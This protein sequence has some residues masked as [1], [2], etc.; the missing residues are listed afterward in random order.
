VIAV[1][2]CN[3]RA[4][5]QVSLDIYNEVWPHD[6]VSLEDVDSYK[7]SLTEHVDLLA[8]VDGRPAG[9]AVAAIQP[10]DPGIVYAL[11]TV[12]AEHRRRGV[13]TAL[14]EAVSG[15]GRE[16]RLDR[17]EVPVLDDDPESLAFAARRGFV[18]ER[19]ETGVVLELAGIEAPA[20]E[21]PPGVEIV[22][23]AER[24]ELARGM[25]EVALEAFPDVPGFEDDMMEPFA[26][27]LAHDMQGSGDHPEATF[28]ALTGDE[29]VGY[30]K[31][32]LTTAQPTSA[33]HDLTGV[34]RAWRGRGVARALKATQIGWAKANG[35]ARLHTRNDER[36]TPIRRLN[37]RFGYRPG[38]GRIHL[39][40]PIAG[41]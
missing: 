31:F 6:K 35:Y 1:S 12:L 37:E 34:K 27:W 10:Q 21:P 3:S 15:W 26:D 16:R 9:S 24:P 5:E 4:D 2:S 25:Y 7:S 23:W 41:S 36:N 20:V 22:T 30:A 18:E 38:I 14:Y 29:V 39:R 17:V 33:Y 32:S 40:G 19:R 8:R 13:G 11:A 28:V